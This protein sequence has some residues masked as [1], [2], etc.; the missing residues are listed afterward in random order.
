VI[1]Q[2]LH[3]AGASYY[4]WSGTLDGTDP[5]APLTARLVCDWSTPEDAIDGFAALFDSDA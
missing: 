5:D 4:L 1:H 3:A 2:R